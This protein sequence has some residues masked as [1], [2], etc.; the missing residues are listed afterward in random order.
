M[1]DL[2]EAGFAA[3]A[4]RRGGFSAED[5]TAGGYTCKELRDGGYSASDLRAADHSAADLR[6]ADG[7]V[8]VHRPKDE[9]P[10]AHCAHVLHLESAMQPAVLHN[11]PQVGHA[12]AGP[13]S[14]GGAR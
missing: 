7:V 1:R 9:A 11:V 6:N 8:Q 13:D 5:L 3:G 10:R 4:L 14:N 2:K 12:N